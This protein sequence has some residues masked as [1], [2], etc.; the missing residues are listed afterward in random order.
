MS[1]TNFNLVHSWGQI[2]FNLSTSLLPK[3]AQSHP[4]R[5]FPR[6][7]E[8]RQEKT[9]LEQSCTAM[10]RV[11]RPSCMEQRLLGIS[12]R[13]HAVKYPLNSQASFLTKL[14]KSTDLSLETILL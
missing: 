10:G 4:N 6:R 3:V 13:D 1:T 9:Q 5:T 8:N 2:A 7:T 11:E 14:I 12:L